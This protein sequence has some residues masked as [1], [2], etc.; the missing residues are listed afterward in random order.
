[1]S[2]SLDS[3]GKAM[4]FIL[5]ISITYRANKRITSREINPNVSNVCL[6]RMSAFVFSLPTSKILNLNSH[7]EPRHETNEIE[8]RVIS[9]YVKIYICG[10]FLGKIIKSV[11]FIKMNYGESGCKIIDYKHTKNHADLQEHSV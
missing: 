7:S 6:M 2:A 3:T 10:M 8:I 11:L 1:M 9:C 5:F 4:H